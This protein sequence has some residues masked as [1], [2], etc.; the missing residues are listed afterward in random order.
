VLKRFLLASIASVALWVTA[1]TFIVPRIVAQDAGQTPTFR[2]SAEAV[3]ITA[4]VTDADGNPVSGLTEDDFEILENNVPQPITTFSAVN[5]PIERVA[6]AVRDADVLTNE[7]PPG[8]LYLIALDEVAP[9]NALRTRKFLRD[10]VEQYFGPNDKAAVVLMGRGLSTSGQDFTGS[11]VL[12]LDAIDR[13]TG[14]FPD[15]PLSQRNKMGTLRD[16]MEFMAKMPGPRKAVILF[17]EGI[18]ADALDLVDYR[19]GVLSIAGEDFQAAVSAATRGNVAIYPIDPRG[20][21]PDTA[22]AGIGSDLRA[23]AQVTGGFALT[24]ANGFKEAFERLVRENSTYYILGFNSSSEK[25]NAR[26]VP[27]TVRVKNP[28]LMI[29]TV[30]GYVAPRG[31]P[32]ETKTRPSTLLSAVGDAV[33]S[34]IATSGVPLHMFAAPFRSP[35][36]NAVVAISLELDPSRLGLVQQNGVYAGEIEIV[37][38]VTD[39]KKKRWPLMRHRARLALKPDTYERARTGGLRVLSQ[40]LLPEG[41]YQI[42]ASAGAAT[43]AGSVVYDLKVPKFS[44]GLE[45]SG[46]SVTSSH[47]GDAVTVSPYAQLGVALPG[48]PMTARTFRQDD[49]LTLFVEVY[50][51]RTKA[52]AIEFTTELRK[53]SGEVVA[54]VKTTRTAKEAPKQASVYRFSPGLVLD[55]LPPGRYRIHVEAHSSLDKN[56]GVSRDVPITVE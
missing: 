41:R 48:P 39:A 52:H 43:L 4:I 22:G 34:P 47:A 29:N 35:N 12:L 17:S 23:L 27:L 45:M 32:K 21:S 26:Y 3:Q 19:G 55:D 24:N 44:D 13:F 50:E 49:S 15:D 9:E 2:A 40:L 20:L 36:K 51:N 37:F 33:R 18:G 8:R 30:E 53:E 11:P 16:L 1:G 7:A 28:D 31:K 25:R 6:P 46:V 56:A 42:R 10:F 54:T 14:G 38:A 5:I